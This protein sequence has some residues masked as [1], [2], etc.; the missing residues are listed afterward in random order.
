MAADPL[1][2]GLVVAAHGRHYVVE[3]EDGSQRHCFPRGKRSDVTVG[4]R[5][6]VQLSGENEGIIQRTQPRRNLLFR[7]DDARTKQFAANVDQ[8]FIVVAVTPAFSD[9]LISRALVAAWSSQIKPV[10][11]LNKTDLHTHLDHART[12]L[13]WLQPLS[14]PVIEVSALDAATCR[15]ALAPWL[16]NRTTLLLGQSAMGKSSILNAL[17]PDANAVTREHSQALG[18]GRHTTTSS[19]LYHLPDLQASLID[20]PGFQSFGLLHLSAGEIEHGFPEFESANVQCRF[21]NCTHRHEPGCGVLQRLEQGLITPQRH[22]LYKRL[23]A[24][25]EARP[26]Y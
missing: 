21:Y 9:D 20:S 23:L 4:D 6:D 7:S 5:V 3:L 10:V 16:G 1:H 22:A 8:L 25:L 13:A 2:H 24:E 15:D 18:S 12:Q 14:V 26:R 17:V 19:R 11:V